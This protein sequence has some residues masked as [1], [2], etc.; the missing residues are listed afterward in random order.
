MRITP[1]A[2]AFTRIPYRPNSR[3]ADRAAPAT[4][5]FAAAYAVC[6]TAPC[7]PAM[8]PN[9]TIDPE[10]LR[11]MTWVAARRLASVPETLVAIMRST[12]SRAIIPI[13]AASRV[14]AAATSA[15]M[16]P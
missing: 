7:S 5:D 16:R 1:G 4:A 2:T 12:C 14:P 11:T 6:P 10:R 8:E 9:S 13:G 3:A 15:S